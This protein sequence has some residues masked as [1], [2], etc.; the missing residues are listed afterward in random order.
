MASE[1]AKVGEEVSVSNWVAEALVAAA[2]TRSAVKLSQD[3]LSVIEQAQGVWKRLCFPTPKLEAWKYTNPD[4]IAKGPF[5]WRKDDVAAGNVDEVNQLIERARLPGLEGGSFLVFV[6]GVFA[7]KISKVATEQGVSVTRLLEGGVGESLIGALG[8]HNHDEFSALATSLLSDCVI[9]TVKAGVESKTP[10]QI[11]HVTTSNS[12]GAVFTP[13]LVVK[14][15]ANA[16]VCV[17]ES[18]IGSEGVRYLSL[19]M[20]ELTAEQGAFLDY[21]K[22][23]DE[24]TSAYHVTGLTA[25]QGRDAEARAHIFSF[26]AALARNNAQTLLNGAGSQATLNGLSLLRGNQHVDNAT[27]IHHIEP[28]A[29]SREHFKGIYAGSSR[30]VFSG[31]ITVEKIAQKTNAFQSNQALLL[32]TDASIE[33]RPQLKIWAD[34]VK[35]THGATVGQLDADALFYLRSRG[36]GIKDAK[37]FLVRAFAG[38]VLSSVNL[39]Q[40]KERLDAVVSERL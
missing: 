34:D 26:G 27:L 17:V 20:V 39:P 8:Q 5:S 29:E 9:V 13:R 30:G 3:V 38:E 12:N 35:C 23:Q 24:S 10:I 40:L 11:V 25:T 37:A 21:Y 33:S 22:V 14:A 31:T 2:K 7:P 28:H 36:I 19:P 6:D 15:E 16:R 32:S 4:V 18:H 1:I